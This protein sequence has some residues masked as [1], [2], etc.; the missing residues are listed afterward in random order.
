M[1]YVIPILCFEDKRIMHVYVSRH[2]VACLFFVFSFCVCLLLFTMKIKTSLYQYYASMKYVIPILCFEDKRIMHVYVSRHK[3]ACLF[4]V[5][6]FCVCL[7][8]FT[9]KIKTSLY[10]YY[11][12]MKYVIPILCF[13]DK[14]ITHV[15][16]SRH[17]LSFH[18]I[19]KT[20][21]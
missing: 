7:L 8:L 19:T 12:S 2:K 18:Y 3:V 20:L 9:M 17:N 14:R 6:S 10:Q 5:F 4:F 16:V 13:E 1:K 11:A 15:Y 21:N